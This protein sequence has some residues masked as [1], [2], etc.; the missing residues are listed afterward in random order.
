M[1]EG[2]GLMKLEYRQRTR[3]ETMCKP[4][5]SHRLLNGHIGGYG[6]FTPI[7]EN[8]WENKVEHEMETAI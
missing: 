2:L 5:A 3:T 1:A 7:V 6:D 4:L 8:Q